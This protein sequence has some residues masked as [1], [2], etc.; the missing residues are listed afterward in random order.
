MKSSNGTRRAGWSLRKAYENG[1]KC[2]TNIHM[3]LHGRAC[4]K[5]TL[6]LGPNKST[7][8]C[9][10]QLLLRVAPVTDYKNEAADARPGLSHL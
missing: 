7:A 10:F 6:H 9:T 3:H 2:G 5:G 4:D 8:Q 1:S